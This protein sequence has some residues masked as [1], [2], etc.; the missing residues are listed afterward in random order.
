MEE[1]KKQFI[2]AL[3]ESPELLNYKW[4]ELERRFG[5]PPTGREGDRARKWWKSFEKSLN[6]F[7]KFEEEEVRV[8][9]KPVGL[10]VKSVWQ[11]QGKGG[12]IKT[13][14]SYQPQAID[15]QEFRDKLVEDLSKFSP[16]VK[17]ETGYLEE[18]TVNN[19]LEI[20]IPDFHIG[21][22]SHEEASKL[23]FSAI[24][25]F[26]ATVKSSN[27]V[28][29]KIVFPV[30]NDWLNSD[31]L[32]YATTKGTPQFDVSPW[33]ETFRYGWQ[34]LATAASML[35]QVAPV[36]I[37][38]VPGNHDRS[39]MFYI[40]DVLAAYFKNSEKV[41]VDNRIDTYKTYRFGQNL[42]MYHH[43]DK[44]GARNYA[45]ILA[46]EAGKDWGETKFREVHV[47]HFHKEMILDEQRG[48]KVRHL[49]SLAKENQYERSEGYR[50]IAQAQAL[51]WNFS[52]GLT[53][54]LHYTNE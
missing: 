37:V 21:R 36:S 45:L 42:I 50:H 54:I 43:G 2:S 26:I 53:N 14:Y 3:V 51:V 19:L 38:V 52:R 48:V 24:N 8:D 32:D 10:K 41:S 5:I 31:N 33:Y 39:R 27:I 7:S 23:F 46:D 20:A 6:G 12:E 40:G 35:S 9:E 13:L 18:T 29:D 47:G 1:L 22:L 11:V 34:A 28:V 30:G 44:I 25:Y 17:Q 49:P 4:A 16:I 15:N